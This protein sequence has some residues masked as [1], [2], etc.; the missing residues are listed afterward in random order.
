MRNP[1]LSPYMWEP[2][3]TDLKKSSRLAGFALTSQPGLCICCLV[4]LS[5]FL[6][7]FISMHPFSC[8]FSQTSV[9]SPLL[10]QTLIF[11]QVWILLM[12]SRLW[13]SQEKITAIFL[14]EEGDTHCIKSIWRWEL[15]TG[16]WWISSQKHETSDP[17]EGPITFPYKL[18]PLHSH[19]RMLS[20]RSQTTGRQEDLVAGCAVGIQPAAL[21][22]IGWFSIYKS[23][24]LQSIQFPR[25]G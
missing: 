19:I 14:A 25:F 6:L 15:T 21:S 20:S 8:S 16:W 5:S 11:F 10:G 13:P 7:L 22:R 24:D 2:L 4:T 1:K 9:F 18:L 23:G 3:P 17:Q 12:K